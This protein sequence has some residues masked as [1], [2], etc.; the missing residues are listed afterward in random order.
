[1]GRDPHSR[2]DNSRDA[3]LVELTTLDLL[4]LDDFVLEPMSR[5]ES[6]DM[7]QLFIERTSK[8]S[9]I[10]TSNR[11]TSD[12][13]AFFDENILAQSA[14]DRFR[15]NAYD[16]VIEGE[17]YRPRLK[18]NV[19]KEGPPPAAPVTKKLTHRRAPKRRRH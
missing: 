1:M 14:L 13:L 3:L 11:D 8:A 4:I 5:D 9:T 6:R 19:D 15:N 12:W 17:S 2:F 7:Y 10:I 16:L 18:P